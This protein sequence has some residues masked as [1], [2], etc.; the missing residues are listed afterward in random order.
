MIVGFG[1][2]AR[3]GKDTAATALVRDLGFERIGFADALK[4][5][6]IGIDPTITGGGTVNVG[7]GRGRLAHIVGGSNWEQ[8]KDSY[9]EVRRFLENLGKECRRVFGDEIWLDKVLGRFGSHDNERL[10]IPDVR[11]LNEAE[12]IQRIGGYVIRI[13]RPGFQ[14]QPD[15]RPSE[16]PLLNW[17]GW[18]H[19]IKN[20]GDIQSLER[21]IV[22][23]VKSKMSEG[24][25]A[26]APDEDLPV[27]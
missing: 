20:D 8:A 12:G 10:V 25:T 27:G 14:A 22:D 24:S 23:W 6:A 4:D 17:D 11:H 15:L 9:P 16:G 3:V 7:I 21:Q 1:N 13:D 19:I 26:E 2:A 18:D 5:L